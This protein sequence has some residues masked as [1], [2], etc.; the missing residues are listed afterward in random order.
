MRQHQQKEFMSEIAR[1]LQSARSAR[2][3]LPSF[4]RLLRRHFPSLRCVLYYK[5]AEGNAFRPYGDDDTVQPL[6][7]V[8]EEADLIESFTGREEAMLA[9]V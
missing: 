6:P 4:P 9:D 1:S 3:F 2:A 5:E 7:L 8:R